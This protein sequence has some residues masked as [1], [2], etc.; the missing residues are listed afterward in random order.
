[1]KQEWIAKAAR[2]L[3]TLIVILVLSYASWF[4][5]RH[6]LQ[7]VGQRDSMFFSV[8]IVSSAWTFVFFLVIQWIERR[9]EV[10]YH[11]ARITKLMQI[12]PGQSLSTPDKKE[13]KWIQ[14]YVQ[15]EDSQGKSNRLMPVWESQKVVLKRS[16][17]ADVA[18]YHKSGFSFAGSLLTALGIL[19]TFWGISKGLSGLGNLQTLNTD[20][21][22]GVIQPLLQGM[23]TAFSTSLLGIGGALIFLLLEKALELRGQMHIQKL[24]QTLNQSCTMENSIRY[25]RAQ[26]GQGDIQSLNR[27]ILQMTLAIQELQKTL[28]SQ[29]KDNPMNTNSPFSDGA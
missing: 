5:L 2:A 4:Q 26:Q 21:L 11:I 29:G 14:E 18:G 20:N 13:R 1:M 17:L 23:S 28:D 22:L 6:R 16:P 9:I 10:S 12:S 3:I 15:L 8:L 19:G 25:L 24:Q 7:L 27:S